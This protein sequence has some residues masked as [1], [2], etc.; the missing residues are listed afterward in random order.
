MLEK[1]ALNWRIFTY[2]SYLVEKQL[3]VKNNKLYFQ[4]F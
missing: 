2:G 1:L 3:A 4:N